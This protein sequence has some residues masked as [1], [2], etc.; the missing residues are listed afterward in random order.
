KPQFTVL[1]RGVWGVVGA[2]SG[3]RWGSNP[4]PKL[5]WDSIR[6]QNGIDG[7]GFVSQPGCICHDGAAGPVRA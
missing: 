7:P 6:R 3:A 2:P 1:Q 5:G 4:A